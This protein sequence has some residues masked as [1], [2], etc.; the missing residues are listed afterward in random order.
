MTRGASRC[1]ASHARLE[2]GSIHLPE[3]SRLASVAARMEAEG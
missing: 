1:L 2:P 3:E